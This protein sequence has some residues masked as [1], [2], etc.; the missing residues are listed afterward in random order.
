MH[1]DTG[2]HE[3]HFP[4]QTHVHV[5]AILSGVSFSIGS[6]PLARMQE[7][8]RGARVDAVLHHR[9]RVFQKSVASSAS[10]AMSTDVDRLS[11]FLSHGVVFA[12]QCQRRF[13][14]CPLCWLPPLCRHRFRSVSPDEDGR[15]LREHQPLCAVCDGGRLR[16]VSGGA[17]H[18][19]RSPAEF[20]AG[21]L[22]QAL[23]TTN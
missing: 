2:T 9:A 6:T 5:H 10:F 22:G 3:H 1:A 20:L 11:A 8:V 15:D 4:A 21:L 13:R 18:G 19:P 23:R 7:Y 17:A 12:P 16:G 14:G